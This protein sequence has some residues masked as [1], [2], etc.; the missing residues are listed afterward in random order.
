M[1]LLDAGY[2]PTTYW[3]SR[4][5]TADYWPE[6]GYVAPPEVVPRAG[7]SLKLRREFAERFSKTW[8]VE[9]VVYPFFQEFSKPF[10]VQA[11]KNADFENA[12]VL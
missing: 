6:Y 4:Y 11:W 7:V 10:T 12:Y 3:A 1:A 5:W 2:W 9:A 8:L